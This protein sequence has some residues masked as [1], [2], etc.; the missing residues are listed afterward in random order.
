MEI[1]DAYTKQ[2][3]RD[4]PELI[5]AGCEAIATDSHSFH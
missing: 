1:R 4:E 2:K 3:V 5:D